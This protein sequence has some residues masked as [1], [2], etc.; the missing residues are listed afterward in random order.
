MNA[1]ES[2]MKN[3]P[4]DPLISLDT[5]GSDDLS[6]GQSSVVM[7]SI[8]PRDEGE[9]NIDVEIGKGNSDTEHLI[10]NGECVYIENHARSDDLQIQVSCEGKELF[11]DH[12]PLNQDSNEYNIIINREEQMISDSSIPSLD[13]GLSTA[14][15][16]A[17]NDQQL[18]T[19]AISMGVEEIKLHDSHQIDPATMTFAKD[20][21]DR[22]CDVP[23]SNDGKDI[24]L[25]DET[26]E[27]ESS[28][29]QQ[30]FDAFGTYADI[31]VD[32]QPGFEETVTELSCW[33]Q[34]V[35]DA[36]GTYADIFVDYHPGFEET[37]TELNEE[38]FKVTKDK[39]F[40]ALWKGST[41]KKVRKVRAKTKKAFD[42]VAYHI[43]VDKGQIHSSSTK[44]EYEMSHHISAENVARKTPQ[45]RNKI[46]GKIFGKAK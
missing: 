34:Q 22:E 11:D 44:T 2:E 16:E 35:F 1:V 25:A 18:N 10:H 7:N 41:P 8:K 43:F 12:P 15:E 21:S 24:V 4:I 46:L 20:S 9:C 40:M 14:A 37:V 28:W 17:Q 23:K 13:D 3:I 42:P 36:F 33:I 45:R 5:S 6:K 19:N 38:L 26:K 32:Y 31:F 39:D 27:E 30:V 29:I